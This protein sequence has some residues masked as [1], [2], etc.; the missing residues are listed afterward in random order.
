M[1]DLGVKHSFRVADDTPGILFAVSIRPE[2]NDCPA[3]ST[4]AR[5]EAQIRT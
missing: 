2:S 4:A 3:P 1:P 5:Q